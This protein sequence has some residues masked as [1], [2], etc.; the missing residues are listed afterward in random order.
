MRAARI[1]CGLRLR[2]AAARRSWLAKHVSG[3]ARW[4]P[5]ARLAGASSPV[6][7]RDVTYDLLVVG[8]P[9]PWPEQAGTPLE[10]RRLKFVIHLRRVRRHGSVATSRT[11]E[12][13]RSLLLRDRGRTGL[14]QR[15]L[16]LRAG[17]SRRSVQDWEAGL[18]LPTAERLQA[19]I[20]A[21]LETGGLTSGRE[22][23]EARELWAAVEREG[24]RMHAP[25]DQEWFAGMLAMQDLSKSAPSGARCGAADGHSRARPG[26][27]RSARHHRLRRPR[28]GAGAAAT[29]GAGRTQSPGGACWAW[30]ALARPAWPPGW[31]RPWRRVFCACTGARCAMRHR[32]ASGWPALSAFLSDQQVVPPR[33]ESDADQRAA[34]VA[35]RPAVPAGARQFRDPVRARPTRGSLS[36]RHGWLRSG[37]AGHR[38]NVPPELPGADQPRGPAG[39]RASCPEHASWSSTAWASPKLRHCWPTST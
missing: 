32:S 10:L 20:R 21:L 18:T 14:V 1:A 30:V 35:A 23:S 33:S 19:L 3:S 39:A 9:S 16:A 13:F 2:S 27:G 12:S 29:L 22:L 17:V 15:D 7:W 36:S 26:L 34:A 5:R 37:A 6:R 4:K 31:P 38:R 28:R 25:F 11:P 24:T 8:D